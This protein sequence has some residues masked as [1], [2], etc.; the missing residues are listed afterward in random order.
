MKNLF[1][2]G[3]IRIGKSTYLRNYLNLYKN[4]TL[5]MCTQRILDEE[6]NIVGYQAEFINFQNLP[7][8]NINFHN[9]LENI[10]IY[11][12]QFDDAKIEYIIKKIEI[13]LLLNKPS[14]IILDEIGG[15]E[16][17]NEKILNLLN[18]ILSYDIPCVGT[19][20][21]Y[22]QNKSSIFKVNYLE[23][24]QNFCSLIESNGKILD[25]THDTLY[26]IDNDLKILFKK[27]N[28]QTL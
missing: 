6:K 16:L 13:S 18:T 8:V 12:G 26:K 14:L 7:H 24:Y 1:I 10:F 27:Y 3:P 21:S 9:N 20:K 4:N 11:N 2:R 17:K 15:F 28:F 23:E 19:L 22:S 25:V 5:G